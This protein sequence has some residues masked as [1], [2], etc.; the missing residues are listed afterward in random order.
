MSGKVIEVSSACGTNPIYQSVEL[1]GF[2]DKNND[3]INYYY[4]FGFKYLRYGTLY[5]V[6][7]LK[8]SRFIVEDEKVSLTSDKPLNLY[9]TPS[10]NPG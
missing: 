3:Y 7:V 5:K 9:P 2:K 6:Q 8:N 10:T 4:F 1:E